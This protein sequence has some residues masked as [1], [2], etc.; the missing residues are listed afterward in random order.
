MGGGDEIVAV[1][2]EDDAI[3]ERVDDRVLDAGIIARSWRIRRL[4]AP[5][6]ALLVAGRLRLA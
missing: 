5:E 1:G 6:I 4:R 3:D 2:G